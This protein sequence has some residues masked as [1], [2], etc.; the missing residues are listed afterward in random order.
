MK[1]TGAVIAAAGLSSRMGA[2]KP[3][4]P[5]GELS[6][7][8]H[9][10]AMLKEE[11]VDPI[12]VVTGFRGRELEAELK[13]RGVILIRNEQYA[14]TEMLDSLRLGFEA[15]ADCCDQILV[16]PVD[17]PAVTGATVRRVMECDSPIVRTKSMDRYGHPVKLSRAMVREVM[18]YRGGDGLRGFLKGHTD[19]VADVVVYDEGSFTDADTRE[20]Y[21]R[22]L[23]LNGGRGKGYP[24]G[25]ALKWLLRTSNM[26]EPVRRHSEA[27][28][29]KAL[30]MARALERAGI[31]LDLDLVR[32]ASLL[33]DIGKGRPDHARLGADILARS[34][35]PAAA[36]IVRQ[37]HDLDCI[38]KRADETLVVYLAD[39][40]V[41][42][43]REV[44]LEERFA[45]SLGKC[46]GNPE[47]MKHFE[48]R[49]SQACQ[50]WRVWEQSVAACV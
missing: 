4:L 43:D 6:V 21:R 37:H 42:G 10:T 24:D 36:E 11:G 32:S 12:A 49:R 30:S 27:V 44:T 38:P 41:Q 39:K 50:A 31:C 5:F 16:M 7:A 14:S 47:A 28:S 45:G 3:L 2:F 26:P 9:L 46:V 20:E 8:G 33:H 48:R 25:E 15:V 23:E 35:Y 29:R 34:G 17:V 18:A 1:R 40:M 13:D 22:L 19:L